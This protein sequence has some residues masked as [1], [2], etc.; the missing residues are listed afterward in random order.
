MKRMLPPCGIKVIKSYRTLRR[1]ETVSLDT[2][3]SSALKWTTK[4]RHRRT[5]P[6]PHSPPCVCFPWKWKLGLLLPSSN[7]STQRSLAVSS[8]GLPHSITFLSAERLRCLIPTNFNPRT[9][10]KTGA[11][12]TGYMILS[13]LRPG[14]SIFSS[15]QSLKYGW[16]V[17]H[18][19]SRESKAHFSWLVC[20]LRYFNVYS[21]PFRLYGKKCVNS[22]FSF[23]NLLNI[24]LEMCA[25]FMFSSE[26]KPSLE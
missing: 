21:H 20:L 19:V 22:L 11:C 3:F 6:T 17:G 2:V 23:L 1:K 12:S 14:R 15:C 26:P 10:W 18:G 7:T 9:V 13:A 5:L 16:Y 8:A 4:W 24:M 25:L